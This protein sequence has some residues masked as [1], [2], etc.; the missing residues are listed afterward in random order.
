MAL[1]RSQVEHIAKL[2]RIG[3][4]RADIDIFAEQLSQI[5]EQFEVLSELETEGIEPTSNAGELQ[6]VMREDKC[7]GSLDPG[8]VLRNAPRQEDDFIRVKAVLEE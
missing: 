4:T 6:T 2:A 5:L 8:E 7:E 3:L 1:A